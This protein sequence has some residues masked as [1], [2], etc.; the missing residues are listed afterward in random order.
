MAPPSV[1][2]SGPSLLPP[3]D[4]KPRRDPL[5]DLRLL[6]HCCLTLPFTRRIHSWPLVL[7]DLDSFEHLYLNKTAV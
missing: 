6:H 1:V 2:V 7:T 5:R 4:L 3:E